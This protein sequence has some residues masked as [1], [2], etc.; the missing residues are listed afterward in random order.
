V[1]NVGRDGVVTV[2]FET[3]RPIPGASLYLGTVPPEPT[4]GLARYRKQSTALTSSKDGRK[5]SISYRIG[6]LLK[7]KY[8][9]DD[10]R[11]HG[12]G[13]LAMRLEVLD[14]HEGSTR[15]FDL[16]TR[17]RCLPSPCTSS[18]EVVQLPSF[19][20]APVVDLPTATSVV[21]SFD[22][23][24][25]TAARVVAIA[26]DGK[27]L[28]VDS[29]TRGTH[30]EIQ[31]AGLAGDQPY[32][33]YVFIGDRR[34]ETA[35]SR[36]AV[37]RTAP[38]Q[39]RPISFAVM[40]DSRSGHGVGEQRFAG[41]NMEVLRALFDR[42]DD[43][44]TDFIIF[45]GDEIDGLQTSMP[46]FEYEL[47]QWR[48]VVQPWAAM[49]PIFEGMG[50][51]E[52]VIEAHVPGWALPLSSSRRA[53]EVFAE[54]FVNPENGPTPTRKDAPTFSEN[55]YSYDYG[56]VH[57]ASITSNYWFRSH[58]AL[59]NHPAG[60]RGHREGWVPDEVLDWLDRD[61]A[62]AR[63]RG[64]KHLFVFTHEPAFPNGGHAKDGMYW[65]G[66]EP[67]VLEQRDRLV[68]ILSR[69]RVLMLMTGDEHN[70]SRMRVD[71][72]A[73]K[74]ANNPFAQ[75]VTGGAGAPY[76][77]QETQVPWTDAVAR[78]STRQHFVRIEVDGNG[79]TVKAIDIGGQVFDEFRLPLQ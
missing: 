9:H 56:P 1:A 67:Q 52:Q 13:I 42:I 69:H 22:T 11:L 32:R 44:P 12:R 39:D 62:D 48:R 72:S 53:E 23:D 70:Y 73:S 18:S 79:A 38:Q 19:S 64:Q 37:F 16:Q 35:T 68:D 6:K 76:Y 14:D 40:S 31:V 78:F 55:T 77:Q 28:R 51:H 43:D 74:A 36:G 24:A 49:I 71:R 75:I 63:K 25:A 54:Q 46:S 66:K 10:L 7:P 8:A 26:P 65:N 57:V 34:G 21:V 50:N 29:K 2:L 33:Y 59:E 47:R 3:I 30:H 15:L 60:D 45:A 17:I 5:H 20:V 41:T 61:L 58:D 27:R 4:L